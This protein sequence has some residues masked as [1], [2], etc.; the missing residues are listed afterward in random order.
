MVTSLSTDSPLQHALFTRSPSCSQRFLC[1]L[2]NAHLTQEA[3]SCCLISFPSD[4]LLLGRVPGASLC[5]R[6]RFGTRS[7][8]L[9]L[10][11]GLRGSFACYETSRLQW[12]PRGSRW[13]VPNYFVPF[14]AV[15]HRTSFILTSAAE[16]EALWWGRL[17]TT[18]VSPF[19]AII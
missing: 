13:V 12:V 4:I 7:A 5:G 19:L 17:L 11:S 8:F 2:L 6:F 16:W 3:L 18:L 9:F 1:A 10:T 14:R 15:R